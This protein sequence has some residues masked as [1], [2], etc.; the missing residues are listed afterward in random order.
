MKGS[1]SAMPIWADFMRSALDLHPEWNGDWQL[2]VSIKKAEIDIRN[3]SLIRELSNEEADSVKA[4]QDAIKKK[5]TPSPGQTPETN[6]ESEMPEIY[7]TNVPLEFRR[8]E[9]FIYG[10]LPQKTLLPTEELD[11]TRPT[12]SPTPFTTWQEEGTTGG[13]TSVPKEEKRSTDTEGKV[14]VMICPISGMRATI[15]C[16]NKESRI[17]NQSQAPKDFCDLHR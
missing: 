17:F 9:L 8:V 15:K 6:P 10:T 13:T 4:Q 3:G 16:P 12:P 14:T 2:P 7:V 1:D 11:L 5:P